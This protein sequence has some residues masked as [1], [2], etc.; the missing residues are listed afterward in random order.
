MK[1]LQKEA[2]QALLVG[3]IFLFS[4]LYLSQFLDKLTWSP[5]FLHTLF[6]DGFDIAFWVILWRPLDFFL[7]ELWPYWR[8]E[9]IYKRM[10]EMEVI[11]SEI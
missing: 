8:E 3:F 10:M 5:A 1:A 9:R 6:V 11:F 7:F 4:G 2:L